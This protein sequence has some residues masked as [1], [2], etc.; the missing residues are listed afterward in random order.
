MSSYSVRGVFI[1]ILVSLSIDKFAC[2]SDENPQLDHLE[3][4]INNA[5]EQKKTYKPRQDNSD[6]LGNYH[7]DKTITDYGIFEYIVA[8]GG[9]SGSV[10]ATRLSEIE[11]CN[12][13]VLE[14]GDMVDDLAEIPFMWPLLQ[15]SD[16]NWGYYTVPQK[17]ACLGW[18]NRQ[19]HYARGKILGGSG[20]INALGYSRGNQEDYNTWANAGN[21]GWSFEEML[22]HFK[23]LENFE[24]ENI[25]L[26]YR[27][28]GGP[29]N[30]AHKKPLED[31][32]ELKNAFAKLQVEYNA[33]YNGQ[34]QMG[35]SRQQRT[36]KNGKRMSGGT[37]YVQPSM[38]RPNFN[39]TL[40]AFVTKI[41]IDEKTKTAK[42][43]LFVLNGKKYR[44]SARK[45][46]ILSAGA[47]NSPQILMLSGIGPKEELEKHSIK[48]IQDLPVGLHAKDHYYFG[49]DLRRNDTMAIQP[50]RQLLKEYLQGKGLLTSSQN[51]WSYAYVNT[52][53]KNS[54]VPNIEIIY[55]Y[56]QPVVG[57]APAE[58]TNYIEEV[59][60]YYESINDQ[61]DFRMEAHMV[62]P[63]SVGSIKL[64]SSDPK[65]FPL[66]DNA[67]LSHKD[68]I[69]VLYEGIQELVKLANIMKVT[70]LKMPFCR[71]QPFDSRE[72]WL[73]AIKYTANHISH[74]SSTVKMGPRSDPKAVVDNK[75]KVYGIKNLRVADCSIMP[76]PIAGHNHAVA[77]VIGE[78]AASLVKKEY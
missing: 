62:Y 67:M 4:L 68:D 3:T 36:M 64:A 50:Y 70:I 26:R 29:I 54:S 42:G 58:Y 45:E 20:S 59:D 38:K 17:N 78:K 15:Y 10:I 14:A 30:I 57:K 28:K 7:N 60:D 48:V 56:Q 74:I 51:T 41:I 40:K 39:V 23:K 49:L 1:T 35:V 2:R 61:T 43:V 71:Q 75:L 72:Y 76:T 27:G 6:Y 16:R 47:V 37:A 31:L 13:L 44:A 69:E 5:L 52:R 65:D 34:K 11:G 33:D 18:K 66:I 55:S 63:K 22:P 24:S 77:L 9:S 19:C 53:N 32:T 12:V 25:D 21:P 73:C 8:G 46:V